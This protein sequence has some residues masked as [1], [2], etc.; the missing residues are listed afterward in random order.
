VFAGLVAAGAVGFWWLVARS[1]QPEVVDEEAVIRD[2]LSE[3]SEA[4]VRAACVA[5]HVFP[6]PDILPREYWPVAVRGMYLIARRRGMELPASED[7]AL[8]WYLLKAPERLPSAPGRTDAG[9]GQVAWALEEWRPTGAPPPGELAPAV[10]HVQA[11]SLF[12]GEGLDLVVSDV[13]TNRVYALRPYAGDAAV[14]EVGT[15]PHPGRVVPTD[16]DGDGAMDLVA[17]ALGDLVPTNDAVGSVVWF[18]RTGPDTFEN[19]VLADGLGRV[20][21]V[22]AADLRGDGGIDL[23]VAVFGHM[24]N[25]GLLL[26]E[27]SGDAGGRPAF[28]H[29]VLDAR[30]G[31]TGV[32]VDDLNGDGR[33][34][35]VAAVAQESQQVVAYWATDDGFRPQVLFQA[36]NPDWGFTGLELT[37]FT[38]NGLPDIVVTNGDNLDLTAPKPYHGVGLLENLGEGRF[39]YRHLTYMYGAHGAVPVDLTNTGRPGL[40]VSAYLPPSVSRRAPPPAEAIV[41]LERVGPTQLVRRVLRSE[42]V[43]YMTLAAGDLTGDGLPDFAVGSMDLGVVDPP[44]AHEGDPLSSFVTLWRN[45]GVRDPGAASGAEDVIDWR[46][47]LRPDS[48]R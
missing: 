40:L 4:R 33:P 7:R 22:Q 17:A 28:V 10:T 24:E 23:V 48:V 29:H 27:R 5:C 15:A 42:G 21:D 13:S 32:R 38:G 45:L 36:P 12:G 3:A 35:V 34:D 20:A 16:L 9:P 31:F 1:G 47:G 46:E 41:W 14:V 30:P 11:V 26:L 39:A 8:G 6:E 25:G 44:Q 2:L 37:D 19:I 43:H 18:R